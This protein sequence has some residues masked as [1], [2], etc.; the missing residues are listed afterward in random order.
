[1]MIWQ[2]R[3]A[4]RVQTVLLGLF[5]LP[6][7]LCALLAIFSLARGL[8]APAASMALAIALL[9]AVRWVLCSLL[10]RLVRWGWIQLRGL[11]G[12]RAV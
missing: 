3:D 8:W 4:Y 12:S 6:Q 10:P 11:C 2:A 5:Y 7:F 9:W 1:M